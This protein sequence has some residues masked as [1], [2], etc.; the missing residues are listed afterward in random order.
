MR[1]TLGM[2]HDLFRRWIIVFVVGDVR[3]GLKYACG[4]FNSR[5]EDIVGYMREAIHGMIWRNEAH[6]RSLCVA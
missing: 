6:D 3:V 2:H 1:E 5:R 4:G